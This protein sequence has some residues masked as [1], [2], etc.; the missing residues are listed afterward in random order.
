LTT[1]EFG[2][3]ITEVKMTKKL[4][5]EASYVSCQSPGKYEQKK[6]KKACNSNLIKKKKKFC[7]MF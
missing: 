2:F 5:S 3:L 1:E 6:C 4:G 7:K